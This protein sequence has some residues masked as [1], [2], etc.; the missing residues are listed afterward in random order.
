MKKNVLINCLLLLLFGCAPSPVLKNQSPVYNTHSGKKLDADTTSYVIGFPDAFARRRFT[1]T[2]ERF[3]AEYPFDKI[4]HKTPGNFFRLSVLPIIPKVQAQE[5][6]KAEP[7]KK[8][9][10]VDTLIQRQTA[11]S[12]VLQQV[13]PNA[14]AVIYAPRGMD[15]ATC[16][17]LSG[18]ITPLCDEAPPLCPNGCLLHL[19][20]ATPQQVSL[21]IGPQISGK[22]GAPVSSLDIVD[23]WTTFVK[24]HPAQG[25]ACFKN[26]AGIEGFLQGREAVIGGFKIVDEKNIVVALRQPDTEA[27]VRLRLAQIVSPALGLGFYGISSP[28]GEETV[29]TANQHTPC[30]KALLNKCII[31]SGPDNNPFVAFSLNKYDILALCGAADIDYARRTL[32]AVADLIPFG[33]DR[34]FISCALEPPDLRQNLM[35]RLSGNDIYAIAKISGKRIG[36]V[37]SDSVS[38]ADSILHKGAPAA[39]SVMFKQP[40]TIIY[41]AEDA[42][43]K[44]IAEKIVADF[45]RQGLACSVKPLAENAYENSLV[46]R[47]YT[48]AVGWVSEDVLA[49]PAL[50]L[51]VASMWF[52]DLGD[53]PQRIAAGYELP[54]FSAN[55]YLLCKKRV[56]FYK[57]AFEGIY[58]KK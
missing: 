42:I 16:R 3:L 28:K 12:Q 39:A 9:K 25:R 52:N 5:A 31:K 47:D 14:T 21:Q 15:D 48:L 37:E 24:Q 51:F 17:R 41:R 58:I 44:R 56:G 50:R 4:K 19:V 11:D 18:G 26:V 55:Q 30:P 40:C 43:S 20:A 27:P 6:P 49:S 23:S 45:A 1:A 53:E 2:F 54:L 36:L 8:E 32:A 46:N 38:A 7:E 22:S 10:F 33:S 29:L 13:A 57:D 34:Y 35:G